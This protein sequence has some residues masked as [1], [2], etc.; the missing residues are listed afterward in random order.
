[1]AKWFSY[2]PAVDDFNVHDTE[3]EAKVAAKSSIEYFRDSSE[4]GWSD[5][6]GQ[7]CW[8]ILSEIAT[9]T[10]KEDLPPDSFFDYHCD[11][12]LRKPD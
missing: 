4:D 2:C 1:M 5:E 10:D 11:Y 3:E 7:V 9:M 6:V 8:G 12:Q